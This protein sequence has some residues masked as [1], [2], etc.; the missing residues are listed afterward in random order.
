M[1]LTISGQA[2]GNGD[3]RVT[4]AVQGRTYPDAPVA[5]DANWL[6]VGVAIV[7]PGYQADFAGRL[8][9]EDLADFL[10]DLEAAQARGHG[11]AALS[12]VE[13]LVELRA[14]LTAAG[15]VRW[16]G[17]T[18]YPPGTGAVLSFEFRGLA[19]DLPALVSDLTAMCR[20][21]PVIG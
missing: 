3:V 18:T 17:L 5:E 9:A 2:E 14:E 4:L 1:K 13:D 7:L 20:K 8:R 19:A 21:Y 12:T 16:C 6:T 15:L 11:Q 10:R